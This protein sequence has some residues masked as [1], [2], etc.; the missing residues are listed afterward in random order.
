[1][2]GLKH[3]T[4]AVRLEEA[5]VQLAEAD[6]EALECYHL[7]GKDDPRTQL[8]R[9]RRMQVRTR[10]AGLGRSLRRRLEQE[11]EQRQRDEERKEQ[12]ERA[13]WNDPSDAR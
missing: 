1:M 2:S 7:Y 4:I 11:E 5:A 13:K 12:E 9:Q 8:A 10:I 3:A 6:D